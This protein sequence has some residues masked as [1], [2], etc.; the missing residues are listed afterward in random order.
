MLGEPGGNVNPS[1]LP[2]AL[3]GIPGLP[4]ATQLVSSSRESSRIAPR[5]SAKIRTLFSL[6]PL[7]LAYL[8]AALVIGHLPV[9]LSYG[10][11][12][13]KTSVFHSPDPQHGAWNI[14]GMK[15]IHEMMWMRKQ[16]GRGR[17]VSFGRWE[18]KPREDTI[19]MSQGESGR[20]PG[21]APAKACSKPYAR[22]PTGAGGWP[23]G[24]G[25]LESQP[26][27]GIGSD[28]VVRREAGR[29]LSRGSSL[30]LAQG[31]PVLSLWPKRRRGGQ[32]H[33][34]RPVACLPLEV[35]PVCYLRPYLE[36][37]GSSWWG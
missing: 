36:V 21:A 4:E 25:H 19:S 29:S 7:H 9:S 24:T 22:G 12:G 37:S 20:P 18:M 10:L 6:F 13:G 23:R 14:T 3:G 32:L 27:G 5:P 28:T 8:R 15:E 35:L 2:S 30:P 31:N 11:L 26:E 33:W 17:R 16:S 1:F 34:A